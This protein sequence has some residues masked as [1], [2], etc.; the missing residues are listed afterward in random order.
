MCAR[1]IVWLPLLLAAAGCAAEKANGRPWIH[2]LRL[3]G[4]KRVKQKD[5]RSKIALDDTSWIPLSPKHYLDP[6]E[7]DVDKKRIEAYY[8]AHGYFFAKVTEA[9]VKPIKEGKA[10]D[11][12]LVVDE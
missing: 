7:V 3:E 5:L 4:V 2:D 8:A 11:I 12:K 6:F 9:D 10:V 1:R